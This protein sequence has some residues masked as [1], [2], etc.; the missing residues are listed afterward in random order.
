MRNA[1][2]VALGVVLTGCSLAVAVGGSSAVFRAWA[3]SCPLTAPYSPAAAPSAGDVTVVNESGVVATVYSYS[4]RGQ[5]FNFGTAATL[6]PGH[7]YDL[8]AG[9]GQVIVVLDP[10]R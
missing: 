1:A 8:S 6:A 3:T 9:L 2:F 7:S 5:L 4:Y 10:D